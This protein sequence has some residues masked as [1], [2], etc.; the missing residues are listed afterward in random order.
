MCTFSLVTLFMM[1]YLTFSSYVIWLGRM[2]FER[3]AV[4][5]IAV[6]TTTPTA[7][8][9]NKNEV[10]KLRRK[11]P[12]RILNFLLL[13]VRLFESFVFFPSLSLAR[14]HFEQFSCVFIACWCVTHIGPWFIRTAE[15][16]GIGKQV[17][18]KKRARKKVKTNML[19]INQM[20]RIAHFTVLRPKMQ[21][22]AWLHL[23]LFAVR[24]IG[25]MCATFHKLRARCSF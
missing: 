12:N 10:D 16:T 22:Y 15:A 21:T 23:L 1:I 6:T 5:T 4:K 2:N 3:T 17:K 8:A 11:N 14:F 13:V 18:K 24:L 9:T 19:R 7:T 20:A 25:I